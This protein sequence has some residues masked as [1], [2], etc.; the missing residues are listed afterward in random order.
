MAEAW[1]SASSGVM[2]P[3]V[4]ISR[5]AVVIGALADAGVF[6]GVTHAGDGRE[7]GINGDDAD[8]L[9]GLLV[10]VAGAEAAPDLDFQFHLELFLLV[11]RA[12]VLLGVD[13]FEVLVQFDVAGGH[14][15]FLVDGE[16]QGLRLAEWALKRIFLRFRTM[17]VTSSTTPSMVANSCMAPSTLM[18]VMAAPSSEESST[19][20]R[21]LPMVWP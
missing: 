5:R 3:S 6:H 11:E 19:R 20:R 15:A 18:E 21:E 1:V 17:S 8:G 7:E 12:D 10:F 16:Q 9:V 14:V 4:Q 2:R 13:Q